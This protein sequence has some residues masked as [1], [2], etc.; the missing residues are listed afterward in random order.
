VN[1]KVTWRGS[2][3]YYSG[4]YL[5]GQKESGRDELI[6]SK[7]ILPVTVHGKMNYIKI[8][9]P[10]PTKPTSNYA[11][12]VYLTTLSITKIYIQW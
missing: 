2:H 11:S 8:T 3:K 9:K 5:E 10:N 4:I 7:F 12:V 6:W 1:Q